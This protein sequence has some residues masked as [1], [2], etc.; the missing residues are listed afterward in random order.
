MSFLRTSQVVTA[1]QEERAYPYS[2]DQSE[3][4]EDGISITTGQSGA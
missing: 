1:F 3:Q 2:S 4:A